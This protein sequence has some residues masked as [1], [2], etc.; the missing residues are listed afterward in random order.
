MIPRWSPLRN[1]PHKRRIKIVDFL[2]RCFIGLLGLL[3][4]VDDGIPLLR[5][6]TYLVAENEPIQFEATVLKSDATHVGT[7]IASQYLTIQKSGSDETER[8][9][10]SFIYER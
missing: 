6:F 1:S 4:V 10:S 9:K 3:I 2:I 7:L 8:L 5:D